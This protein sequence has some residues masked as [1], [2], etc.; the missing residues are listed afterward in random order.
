MSITVNKE[1]T[2]FG[3]IYYYNADEFKFAIYVYD[4]DPKTMYL[5]N[6]FVSKNNRKQGY[7][8]KIL[9]IV[10]VVAEEFNADTIVLKAN[11]QEFVHDW[12]KRHGYID[13]EDDFD[14]YVWMKKTI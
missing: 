8:N 12:Y 5:S 2:A 10:D 6:V 1:N 3:F 4:D 11:K 14:N 9:N 13:C 7:G